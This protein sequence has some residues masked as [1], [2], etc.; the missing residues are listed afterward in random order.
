MMTHDIP[1][2]EWKNFF[3]D[4]SKK[5]LEWQ[6]KIEITNDRIGSQ[7]LDDGLPLVGMTIEKYKDD[8]ILEII[9]GQDDDH[10]QTHNIKNPTKI[11]YMSEEDS[12]SGV[13]EIE[14]MDGT[15]TLV[16]IIQPMPL[17]VRYVK[18][19]EITAS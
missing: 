4:L 2:E 5:R 19:Q 18:S 13:V 14:E 16:H 17:V 7:I 10:H 3:D 8:T 11:A 12:P 6:T 9:V 1:R 15:Q